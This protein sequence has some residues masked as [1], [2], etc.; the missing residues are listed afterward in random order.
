MGPTSLGWSVLIQNSEDR[1]I[2]CYALTVCE[3]RCGAEA[4]VW[5]S[6]RREADVLLDDRCSTFDGHL[7]E[8]HLSSPTADDLG[9]ALGSHV[10][11]PFALSKHRHE[12]LLALMPG[13]DER[14]SVGT[15]RSSSFYLQ[16][17]LSIRRQS[18]GRPPRPK[19]GE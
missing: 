10:L 4:D 12:V 6:P 17:H 11:H 7:F 9:L 1:V 5:S 3:G 2:G 19:A 13:Y 14:E 8:P 16:C 18:E 15:A